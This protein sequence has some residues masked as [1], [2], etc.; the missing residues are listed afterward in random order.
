MIQK[1]TV[2]NTT[3]NVNSATY[4]YIPCRYLIRTCFNAFILNGGVYNLALNNY[5]FG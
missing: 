1:A 5:I 3:L 4:L 2:T